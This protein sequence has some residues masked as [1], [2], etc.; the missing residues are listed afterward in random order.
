MQSIND[1]RVALTLQFQLS[2]L[3]LPRVPHRLEGLAAVA[4]G[5][6]CYHDG[7]V[8][9]GAADR[10]RQNMGAPLW[11]VEQPFND[12][13][14]HPASHADKRYMDQPDQSQLCAQ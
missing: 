5:Q 2:T 6:H 9:L 14:P 10:Q 12:F 11:P 7:A 3:Q 4:F 13:N 8:L 1:G